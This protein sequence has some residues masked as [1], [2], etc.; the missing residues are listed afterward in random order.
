MD[1][2]LTIA[3]LTKYYGGNVPALNN[4]YMTLQ[5][6]RIV[7]LLGPNG[8]GKTT[9]LK[10][11]AGLLTASTGSIQVCGKPIG[12]ES[13]ALVSYLPDRTYLRNNQKIKDQLDFFQDF[14]ADFDRPRAEDMLQKLGISPEQRFG[15]LSKGNKEKVHLVLVMSRRA[16]LYLLDEPIGGVDPAARDYILHT[17]ISNYDPEATVVISTHLI[18]D[19]EPVLDDFVFLFRGN[20]VRAGSVDAV[21]EETGKSLDELFREVF[22]CFPSY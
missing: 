8:S 9:L 19:V 13:K 16:K 4:L 7:G 22:R 14:Y 3:G 5:P 12:P 10:L 18:Q 2:V 15:T 1:N 6:G 17:I 11:V 20:V 21:R